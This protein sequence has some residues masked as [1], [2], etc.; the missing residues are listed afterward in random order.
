MSEKSVTIHTKSPCSS[1]IDIVITL[2]TTPR[3]LHKVSMIR[4]YGKNQ[5]QDGQPFITWSRRVIEKISVLRR[6]ERPTDDRENRMHSTQVI[7]EELIRIWPGRDPIEVHGPRRFYVHVVQVI[8]Y[9]MDGEIS[10][11]CMFRCP[12]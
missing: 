1:Q 8:I 9:G 11:R 2:L 12:R 5:I 6:K 4:G 7:L 10:F 3:G